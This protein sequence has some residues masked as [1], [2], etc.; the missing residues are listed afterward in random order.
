MAVGQA[1]LPIVRV[2]FWPRPQEAARLFRHVRVD[3]TAVLSERAPSL[4][5]GELVRLLD[6]RAEL[7]ADLWNDWSRV[8]PL[9]LLQSRD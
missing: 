8:R 3:T 7:V 5:K 1:G 9:L 4:T 2:R 6:R